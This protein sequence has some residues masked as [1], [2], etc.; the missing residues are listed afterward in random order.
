VNGRDGF[1]R[2]IHAHSWHDCICSFNK[3]QIAGSD[4]RIPRDS[5][6]VNVEVN[7]LPSVHLPAWL[8]NFKCTCLSRMESIA[9]LEYRNDHYR[10]IQGP[11]S[12]LLCPSQSAEVEDRRTQT[13]GNATAHSANLAK[14]SL[15][16]SGCSINVRWWWC[17][18]IASTH[19]PRTR[20]PPRLL[21]TVCLDRPITAGTTGDRLAAATWVTR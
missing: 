1:A 17:K 9:L 20:A 21:L 2:K 7:F 11:Y 19:P 18:R 14:T 16:H 10:N 4:V 6:H 8:C 13:V 5:P 12:R 3:W 15:R